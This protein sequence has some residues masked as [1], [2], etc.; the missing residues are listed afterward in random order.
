MADRAGLKR[1][2]IDG[3]P[4]DVKGSVAVRPSDE[5][6]EPI[7]GLDGYHGTKLV[8]VAPGASGTLT[9]GAGIKTKDLQAIKDKEVFFELANGKSYM[10]TNATWLDQIELNVDEGEIPF[11]F[12]A[13]FCNE[14]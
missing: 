13:E 5:S 4:Y 9:D 7:V 1:M 11:N 8:P 3:V 2:T 12:S 10:L 6:R 14:Y